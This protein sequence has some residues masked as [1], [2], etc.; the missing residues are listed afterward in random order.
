[1]G[2]YVR[3][4]T[5]KPYT[6]KNE[7]QPYSEEVEALE[8]L[9]EDEIELPIFLGGKDDKQV[10][11]DDADILD[12]VVTQQIDKDLYQAFI[13]NLIDLRYRPDVE[14]RLYIHS[15]GGDIISG[16]GLYYLL[17]KLPNTKVGINIG[18]TYSAAMLPFLAC[19]HRISVPFGSFLIH[20]TKITFPE[21]LNT[22]T[23]AT[24]M[25]IFDFENNIINKIF[26]REMEIPEEELQKYLSAES[27][28]TPEEALKLNIIHR[29]SEYII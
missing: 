21:E 13:E 2:F 19:D 18:Y 20:D 1:M 4:S 23:L 22:K 24:Q 11:A 27:Y 8:E 16:L 15:P 9:E 29:I 3:Y 26:C 14:I 17:K 10:D 5:R 6:K 28:F 12:I 7:S 25:R